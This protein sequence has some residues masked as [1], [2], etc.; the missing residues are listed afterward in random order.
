M[1]EIE[2]ET[3]WRVIWFPPDRKD[4]IRT[5]NERQVKKMAELHADFAPIIETR[6]I[7]VGQWETFDPDA[8]PAEEAD[9]E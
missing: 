5:G 4:V 8:P 3:Q 1:Q 6:R 7:V 9:D 2:S